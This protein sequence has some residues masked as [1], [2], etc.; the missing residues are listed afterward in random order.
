M[1][2]VSLQNGFTPLT[3]AVMNGHAGVVN[4]LVNEANSDCS[5]VPQVI[6]T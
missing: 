5:K 6:L 3:H 1:Y 2:V 4:Y